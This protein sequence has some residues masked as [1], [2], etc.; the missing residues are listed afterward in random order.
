VLNRKNVTG[1]KN[2]LSLDKQG[3]YPITEA[4]LAPGDI[5]HIRDNKIYHNVSSI[6]PLNKSLPFERFIIIINS[7]FNDPFQNKVLREHFPD[8][9]LNEG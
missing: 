8:A 6:E 5:I 2:T 4:I 7:R 3:K 9:I 1:G